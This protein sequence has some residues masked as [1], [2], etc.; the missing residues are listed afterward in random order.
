MKNN[1]SESNFP[2][3]E[4]L[5][6]A[7]LVNSYERDDYTTL[8]RYDTPHVAFESSRDGVVS[9]TKHVGSW[10][11]SNLEDLKAYVKMREPGG[12]L[13]VIRLPTEDLPKY[14]AGNLPETREL[15]REEENYIVDKSIH[16]KT[17]I[18]IP[19]KI[20]T[21]IETK[22]TMPD[23]KTIDSFIDGQLSDANLIQIAKSLS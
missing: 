9:V 18:T 13:V 2:H 5:E 23:W 19:L 15:D 20:P 8:Y 14:D 22:F 16:A 12:N 21:K 10:F 11:T 4:N 6:Q 7:E 3:R 17:I 1:P